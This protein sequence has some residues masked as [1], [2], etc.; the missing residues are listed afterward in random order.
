MVINFYN[1]SSS[2]FTTFLLLHFHI[3]GALSARQFESPIVV[4]G[5]P[6]VPRE[7]VLVLDGPRSLLGLAVSVCWDTA[8]SAVHA[9]ISISILLELYCG[10]ALIVNKELLCVGPLRQVLLVQKSADETLEGCVD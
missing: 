5:H 2:T 6:Q 7:G 8:A 10:I 9:R 1:T 4:R 3:G